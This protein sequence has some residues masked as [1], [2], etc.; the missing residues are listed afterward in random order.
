MDTETRHHPA[1]HHRDED[2]LEEERDRGGDEEVR[3]VLDPG[4]PGDRYRQHARVQ[5]EDVQ[6]R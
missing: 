4:L 6:Q 5:R 1:Q 2:R 3:R